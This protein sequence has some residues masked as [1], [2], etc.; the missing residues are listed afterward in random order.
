MAR[1]DHG[2]AGT[3]AAGHVYHWCPAVTDKIEWFDRDVWIVSIIKFFI[4]PL[5]G[6]VTIYG[7]N[8]LLPGTFTAVGA[9]VFLIYTAVPTAVNTAMF[10]VEFG[11]NPDYAT[12]VVMN[13][14]VLS[15]LSMTLVIFIGHILFV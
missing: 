13:T 7:A 4:F 6:I 3:D 9:L 1:H 14:T 10:A 11:N 8:A 12:Q 2:L 5:L 15:A